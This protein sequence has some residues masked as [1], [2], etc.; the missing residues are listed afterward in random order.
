M[1]SS[2]KQRVTDE[3][4]KEGTGFAIVVLGTMN[5]AIHHPYWYKFVN[6]LS[7]EEEK[8]ALGGEFVSLPPLAQFKA[9]PLEFFCDPKRWQVTT[10]DDTQSER[11]LKIA[12]LVFDE[13]LPHTP[14]D[15]IGLNF[16]FHRLTP[17]SNV[18]QYLAD[19]LGQ[20]DFKLPRNEGCSGKLSHTSPVG[21]VQL[22]MQ[23]EPSVHGE[24]LVYVAF[25]AHIALKQVERPQVFDLSSLVSE[26]YAKIRPI[27]DTRLST[28][29][30]AMGAG[31][32]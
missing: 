2:G 9:G 30:E 17:L 25:N 31:E 6:L 26:T 28:I 27:V 11:V 3:A 10:S 29:I 7:D 12:G 15:A 23:V 13:Y 20:L 5:P 21:G 4:T 24:H 18:G 1:V 32:K 16:N 22:R 14:V 8:V 19:Q